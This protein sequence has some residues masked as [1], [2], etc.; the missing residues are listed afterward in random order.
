MST[1]P[2]DL[3]GEIDPAQLPLWQHSEHHQVVLA[4]EGD[5]GFPN[6][7]IP[8][9]CV[10]PAGTLLASWD[11]RPT[12][13]DSP[14]ANTIL[15]RRSS[16]LGQTWQ[17]ATEVHAGITEQPIH[18]YSDPSL[19]VDELTGVVFNVHV[20]SMDVGLLDSRAGTDPD[21]RAVMHVEL[22]RS[23]DDGATWTH[24]DITAEVSTDPAERSRFATSGAG[25]QLRQGPWAGRLVQQC[26]II[27]AD[28]RWRAVSLLSDD[29]GATWR[30]GQPVG[31]DMDENKVVE[32]SDGRLMLN[33]RDRGGSGARKVCFSSNGGESYDEP[34]I[35]P[36]L[37]D[38]ANNASIIRLFPNAEPGTA[39][40]RVLLFSNAA[41]SSERAH[42]MVRMSFD[43]GQTW[44]VSREFCPGRIDYSTLCALPDGRIGMLHEPGPNGII[45]TRFSPAW[46]L[47]D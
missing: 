45:F 12:A 21:D 41:S 11:G 42:G 2:Q 10:T 16:D 46:L 4:A 30:S 3:L 33:S 8:A 39:R 23:E 25:I 5:L 38:P 13:M 36:E 43:D 29:H 19:V 37:V 17:D 20:H 32:L 18:G 7:R 40:S 24:R 9:L 26:C 14:G 47:G 15:L 6:H 35:V 1:F 34:R 28:G 44:P 27:D 31:D 22:S